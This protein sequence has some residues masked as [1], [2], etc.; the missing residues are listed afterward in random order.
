MWEFVDKVVYINLD[1]RTDRDT[2]I[3]Q[4]LLPFGNKVTR[5]AAIE[6]TP[7]FI[8]CLKSHIA[9]LSYAKHYNWRNVLVIE[10]DVE[11]NEF[12]TTYPIVEKLAS[13]PYNVIHLG[14]SSPLINKET[15]E[16]YDG[17]T[18]SSYLVNGH[19]IDTLLTCYK[20]ALPKL[21]QTHDESLYG[22]DQCWKKLMKQGGWFAPTPSLM[23]QAPGYSDIRDRFQD[24]RKYWNLSV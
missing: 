23:Y 19:Y 13:Q 18:T 15:Y 8:G 12:D 9:V 4:V 3:R 16:L 1:K 22:S 20:E 24:H 5:L 21:V 10:D 14:P 17:Q 6:S 7:G 2:R 11:W